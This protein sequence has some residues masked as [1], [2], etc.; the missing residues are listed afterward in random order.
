MSEKRGAAV[1]PDD[2]LRLAE[3]R[4][5]QER[6]NLVMVARGERPA[7]LLL[8]NCEIVNVFSGS[9]ERQN[10]ALCGERI[11]G[12]G[13]YEAEVEVDLRGKYL[14]P[15]FIDGH[16]HLESS[17]LS[18]E[19]FAKAVIVHGTTAAVADPHEIANVAGIEGLDYFFKAS[20][21]LPISLYF[22][23]PS[24]VP[25]TLLETSG[26]TLR[27]KDLF[28]L[29]EREEVLG[30]A[31]MMN[32][33]GVLF[34]AED[35]WN[36]LD[37]FRSS[38]IDGHA[39]GLLG[40]ELAAYISAGISSDHESTELEEAREKL[41]LGMFVILR[42]GSTAKDFEKLLPIVNDYSYSRCF[43][44]TDDRDTED[45]IQE[46]HI[47]FLLR[48]AIKTGLDPVRAMQLATI[49]PARYFGLKEREGI[50]PGKYADFVVL[51]SLED[52][53]IE[54]VVKK[55]R[56]VVREGEFTGDVASTEPSLRIRHS[57]NCGTARPED[58]EMEKQGEHCRV[59]RLIPDEIVT[60]EVHLKPKVEEGK[61]ITDLEND[62]VKV[63][64]IERHHGSENKAVGLVQGLGLK[65]GAIGSSVA[66]D[67]H[68]IVLAGVSDVDMAAAAN[69]ISRMD[70]GLVVVRDGEV[71][72][73]LALPLAGLMSDQ[74][75]ASVDQ[76]LKTLRKKARE[77]GSVAENPFMVLSF[78]SLAVIPELKITDRGLV[79]VKEGRLVDFWV[80]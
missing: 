61:V 70:G 69:A 63:A 77:L 71:V 29:L 75:I 50:G 53:R 26:A 45:I 52:L 23:L 58:F 25:A 12:I 2:F 41:R 34:L 44:G 68:N 47:D 60:R 79:Y 66:H 31:E 42:E 7:D 40:K 39:P 56:F 17:M 33:P 65:R 73:S 80:D 24:C 37:L 5:K 57:V 64:V 62:L 43:L 18:P 46:G 72:A 76:G 59:I 36:K 22:M 78:I 48:K 4:V 8:R 27:G 14:C 30:L 54:A 74:P 55:G 28:P 16:V 32:Y 10:V 6:R 3:E 11:T 20:H 15:G 19:E 21:H 67:S 51:S 49:N 13:E 35:V 1:P 38:I 9:I